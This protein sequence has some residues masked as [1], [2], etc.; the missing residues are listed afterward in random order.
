[1]LL[2]DLQMIR[3]PQPFV[4]LLVVINHRFEEVNFALFGDQFFTVHPPGRELAA[5][6]REHHAEVVSADDAGQAFVTNGQRRG[7][8]CLPRLRDQGARGQRKLIL[9]NR[10]IRIAVRSGGIFADE[11]VG[12]A[13]APVCVWDG[14]LNGAGAVRG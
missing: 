4:L 6:F 7:A 8:V 5:E 2:H 11:Y 12:P 10:V 13:F 1:M 3:L 9:R 14:N